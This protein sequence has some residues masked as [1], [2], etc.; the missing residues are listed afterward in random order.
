MR[1]RWAYGLLL[2]SFVALAV[3]KT[4]P[5]K[6]FLTFLA[7]IGCTSQLVANAVIDAATW[8]IPAATVIARLSDIPNVKSTDLL[9]IQD[10]YMKQATAYLVAKA[11]SASQ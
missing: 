2:L 1:V 5:R 7:S 6:E 4:S 9:K 8:N 11:K 10:P 3:A